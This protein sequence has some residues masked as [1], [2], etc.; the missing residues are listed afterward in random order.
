[1]TQPRPCLDVGM[2]LSPIWAMGTD[3]AG[4]WLATVGTDAVRVWDL[5]Q[6]TLLQT[7]WLP[8]WSRASDIP[9]RCA[10]SEDGAGI[11]LVHGSTAY[12]LDRRSGALTAQPGYATPGGRADRVCDWEPQGRYAYASATGDG[13]PQGLHGWLGVQGADQ[14]LTTREFEPEVFLGS[15]CFSRDGG[16]L[17]AG[18][19]DIPRVDVLAPADLATLHQ[20]D[21]HGVRRGDLR[22][23]AFSRDGAALYAAGSYHDGQGHP[24]RRWDEAGRGPFRDLPAA[25]ETITLLHPLPDGGLAFATERPCWGRLAPD[26]TC[27]YVVAPPALQPDQIFLS[28]SAEQVALSPLYGPQVVFSVPERALRVDPAPDPSLHEPATTHPDVAV[29]GWEESRVVRIQGAT[30]SLPGRAR[31]LTILPDGKSCVLGGEGFLL[32]YPAASLSHFSDFSLPTQDT[33]VLS[34]NGSA[35]GALIAAALPGGVIRW[36]RASRDPMGARTILTLY[37]FPDLRRWLLFTPDGYYDASPGAEEALTLLIER[38]RGWA[39][40]GLAPAQL[41]EKFHRPDIID[42]VLPARD[43]LRALAEANHAR[44]VARAGAG[45]NLGALLP[46]QVTI[47]AP[48]DGSVAQEERVTLQV[49]LHS[50]SGAPITGVRVLVDGRPSLFLRGAPTRIEVPLPPGPVTIGV[51]AETANAVGR[52]VVLRLQ[53]GEELDPALA[54]LQPTLYLLAVGVGAYPG[55]ELRLRYPA[56]DA[57]DLT[58]LLQAQGGKLYRGV[59]ARLLRDQEATRQGI[60][61]GLAWLRRQTTDKDVAV[62]FLAGHGLE[63]PGSGQYYFAPH[64]GDTARMMSTMIPDVV[65]REALAGL[66]GKVVLLLDTCHAGRVF[67]GRDLRGAAAWT[68]WI[69]ELASAENGVVVL[70]ATTGRQA[71]QEDPAWENGAF[72]RAVLE[73]L[74]GKADAGSTGRVTVAMLDLYVS[75]R[76]K[77]LT[78]GTQTPT[79]ARP[80][81]TP[82]F[83]LAILL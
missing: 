82:D 26:G 28:A 69:N 13:S 70:A 21:V 78:D 30:L 14:V 20:P 55:E 74:S 62:L 10:L 80:S 40:Q 79:S 56:K 50:P 34:V 65:L 35:D 63:D 81:T 52:P 83:P 47:E 75:D 6:G 58:R 17:A 5:R 44:R 59:E 45:V 32:L 33:T 23:V 72:T 22:T 53:R 57:A 67:A 64:D 19:L 29:V 71:A 66:A 37:L 8:Q 41:R 43:D 51:L 49:A 68:R 60:L 24:V 15:L 27:L 1:M 77:Q 46:P 16:A 42:R 73:A 36:Y 12:V 4:R 54:A 11:S 31:C 25:A 61:E 39:A 9:I 2:H 3:P 48:A 38:A 76:V 7:L 18:F